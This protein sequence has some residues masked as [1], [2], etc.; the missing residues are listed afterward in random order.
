MPYENSSNTIKKISI[1]K[2]KVIIYFPNKKISINKDVFTSF[3]LYEGKQLEDKEIKSLLYEDKMFSLY[4]NEVKSLSKKPMSE[5]NVRKK[6]YE[7]Q[8]NKKDVDYIINKLK[9]NHFIDDDTLIKERV[10]Y[11]LNVS[12]FSQKF[13]LNKLI[14]QGFFKDK[15]LSNFEGLDEN[16]ETLNLK[17]QFDKLLKKYPSDSYLKKRNKIYNKLLILGFKDSSISQIINNY[18][19]IDEKKERA[20]LK[21]EIFKFKTRNRLKY[22]KDELNDV[23]VKKM[24]SKG[25]KISDIIKLLGEE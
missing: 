12:R 9:E 16:V 15:I 8:L 22:D 19:L 3:Y 2:N 11:Y 24:A 13:I 17:Y 25:F 7:K 20:N 6:L 23:I 1:L 18:L 5:F 4:K 10:D 21:M 14:E